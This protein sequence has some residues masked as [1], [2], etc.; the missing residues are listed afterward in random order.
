M[1]VLIQDNRQSQLVA[2]QRRLALT[3]KPL[4]KLIGMRDVANLLLYC[5]VATENILPPIWTELANTGK[6]QQLPVLQFAI[7]DQKRMCAEPEV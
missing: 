1:G 7:D 3:T 5:N 4:S 2:E 6:S